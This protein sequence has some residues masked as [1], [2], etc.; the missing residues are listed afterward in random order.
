[1]FSLFAAVVTSL[2]HPRSI[3][4]P[5][6]QDP[7]TFKQIIDHSEGGGKEEFDQ[8]YFANF[9]FS[10][11]N[12]TAVLYIGGE[13]DGFRRPCC[14]ST[15]FSFV[16]ELNASFFMLE[17]RYYGESQPFPGQMTT[18]N[19]KYNTVEQAVDDLAYFR[20]WAITHYKLPKEC[21]WLLIGGSYPGLLAA[22]TRAKYP[23]KFHAAISSSGVVY[24][25]NNY[26]EFDEQIAI[27]LGQSCATT[28]RIVRKQVD[29][30]LH[31]EP[32][33]VLDLFGVKGL[34]RKNFP[35]VLAEIFSLGP[36][37][38]DRARLC[39]AL[40]RSR[41]DG[42]SP[43]VNLAKYAKEVFEPEYAGGSVIETYSDAEMHNATKE[44]NGPRAWMWMTCNELAYWQVSPGR[45]SLRSP[46]INQSFFHEQCKIIF[47]KDMPI[48]DTK[49]FNDKWIPLLQETS[50]IYYL[51]SSQ[52]PWT[53]TCFTD[54][55]KIGENC[56]IHT[57][58][59]DEV[60][61]CS[62][63]SSP[64][65]TDQ[66]D[67]IRTRAHVKYVVKKWMDED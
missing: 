6:H 30:L 28:A 10:A 62:D 47:D 41:I 63:I 39:A 59:G 23:K 67:L 18:E 42:S 11:D 15:I 61:H 64:K 51:T 2:D 1:M 48:P 8:R 43:L 54:D 37:Y 33:F 25:T 36:Q 5:N 20:D 22:Y 57:I 16:K 14:R 45:L 27:S 17:H 7:E 31:S 58:I 55:D 12:K 35:L 52:D 50:R 44:M 4:L 46:S 65:P 32:D 29:E 21:K 60:G 40:E 3:Y 49:A 56:F 34:E 13:S 53:P 26:K 9:S 38:G 24:A 66:A 19:L